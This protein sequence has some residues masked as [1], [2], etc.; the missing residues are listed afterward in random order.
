MK[1]KVILLKDI[2]SLGKKDDV[3]EVKPGYA[4]NALIPNGLAIEAS[5]G[6]LAQ[7]EARK[8]AQKM[9]EEEN[10]EK[11]NRV[12][13]SLSGKSFE[14]FVK[15]NDKGHMFSKLHLDEVLQLIEM[16]EAKEVIKMP[17]IKQVGIFKVP[18]EFGEKNGE[19]TIEIK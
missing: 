1:I 7:V 13:D 18:I 16:P 9:E 3:K 4:L 8:N 11:I 12:V 10:Q 6:A 5:D 15:K 19:F 17:E 14:L 2:P